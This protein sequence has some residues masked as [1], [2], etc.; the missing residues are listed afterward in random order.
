MNIFLVHYLV[1][2][3]NV[4]KKLAISFVFLYINSLT[5]EEWLHYRQALLALEGTA[6]LKDLGHTVKY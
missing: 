5:V 2:Q 3:D 1:F 6:G 4:E